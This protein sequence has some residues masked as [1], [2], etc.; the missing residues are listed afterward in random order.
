MAT[1]VKLYR[2]NGE[3]LHM[4]SLGVELDSIVS[5][6]QP[7]EGMATLYYDIYKKDVL[8]VVDALIILGTCFTSTIIYYTIATV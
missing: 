7:S 6:C 4:C 2:I 8:A 1:S 3:N 5:Q